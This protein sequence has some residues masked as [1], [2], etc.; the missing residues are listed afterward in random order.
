MVGAQRRGRGSSL[1]TGSRG[2]E[3]DGLVGLPLNVFKYQ[4]NLSV[5]RENVLSN[6]YL[7]AKLRA[8]ETTTAPATTPNNVLRIK[9]TSPAM[10]DAFLI[11][12]REVCGSICSR[13]EVTQSD[14]LH[15]YSAASLGQTG[16]QQVKCG[17][18]PILQ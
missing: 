10:V 9:V 14:Q 13:Y 12:C 2:S 6:A 8:T 3:L 15:L 16:L 11:V 5:P 18:R 1:G 17:G 7:T 4:K